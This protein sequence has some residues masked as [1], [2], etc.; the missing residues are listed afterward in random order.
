MFCAV[1]RIIVTGEAA[2][3]FIHNADSGAG[4]AVG[5]N[6]RESEN[7][8]AH[9]VRHGFAAVNSTAA[10]NG[11]Y[12]I[13]FLN[14]FGIHQHINIF[15]GRVAAVPKHSRNIKVPFYSCKNCIL[16]FAQRGFA[17]DNNNLFAISCRYGRNCFVAVRPNAVIR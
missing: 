3:L 9:F 11:K 6:G 15:I 17:A 10:A 13:G 14:F 16:G 4:S 1:F 8:F 5:S 7:G 12:H 2:I